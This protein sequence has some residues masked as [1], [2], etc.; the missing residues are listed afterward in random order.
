MLQDALRKAL[1]GQEALEARTPVETE[2][3]A[4]SSLSLPRPEDSEWG[5]RMDGLVPAGASLGRW[6]NDTTRRIKE[7]KGAGRRK[8][9]RA[10]ADAR[11]AFLKKLDKAAWRLAKSRWTELGWSEKLYRRIKSE[12]LDAAKVAERLHTRRAETMTGQKADAI[13]AWLRQ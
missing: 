5:Q 7:L 3:S 8:D 4:G 2:K 10:L 1:A 11:S 12:K 9:A 6:D 13:L